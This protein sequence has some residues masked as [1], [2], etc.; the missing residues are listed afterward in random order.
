MMASKPAVY[1][2]CLT[3]LFQKPPITGKYIHWDT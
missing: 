1:E 2:A 3:T